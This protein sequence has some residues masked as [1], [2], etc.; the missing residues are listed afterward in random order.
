MTKL[1]AWLLA[2]I[3]A[4]SA[5]GAAIAF[6]WSVAQFL[7]QR[8]RESRERQFETYHRLVKE[9]VSPDSA[10]GTTWIDRQAA[11]V[12]EL[13]HFPR[14]YGFTERMLKGLE[15]EWGKNPK[16]G[17][18]RLLEEIDLTLAHIRK[19]RPRR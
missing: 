12:F 5:F 10:T 7:A 13:R 14:Y 17:S 18:A 4:L 6:I 16:P 9:L 2:H 3:T 8:R 11:V 15:E 19:R 1:L